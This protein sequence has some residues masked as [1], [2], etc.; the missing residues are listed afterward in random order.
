MS[1]R[2]DWTVTGR[3]IYRLPGLLSI[4][5]ILLTGIIGFAALL[6]AAPLNPEKDFG[7]LRLIEVKPPLKAPDFALKDIRGKVFRLRSLQNNPLMLYFW[8][9]W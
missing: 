6:G 8:A 3:S 7:E 5:S 2:Q 4:L 9:S 1:P